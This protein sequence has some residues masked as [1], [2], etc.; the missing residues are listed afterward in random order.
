[1]I[2]FLE[3]VEFFLF[4]ACITA[5]SRG[6]LVNS[7]Y[8]KLKFQEQIQCLLTPPVSSEA[9]SRNIFMEKNICQFT[10]ISRDCDG[11]LYT[12]LNFV[13]SVPYV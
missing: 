4:H 3:F 8:V 10:K 7:S 1:M 9:Q 6:V 5:F 13:F 2:E 11:H 12:S